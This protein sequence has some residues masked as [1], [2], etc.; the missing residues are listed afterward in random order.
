MKFG[1]SMSTIWFLSIFLSGHKCAPSSQRSNS[2]PFSKNSYVTYFFRCVRIFEQGSETRATIMTMASTKTFQ[3]VKIEFIKSEDESVESED[4]YFLNDFSA[5]CRKMVRIFLL[6]FRRA[7]NQSWNIVKHARQ[8]RKISNISFLLWLLRSMSE[9]RENLSA[10]DS[11]FRTA[12][13]RMY[14]A[15]ES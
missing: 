9:D 4:E 15:V 5:Q 2:I 13:P 10:V 6:L 8:N 1:H 12:G 3:T 14:R 7:C 11:E